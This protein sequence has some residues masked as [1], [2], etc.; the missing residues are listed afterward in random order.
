ML[1][2]LLLLFCGSNSSMFSSARVPKEGTCCARTSAK[3]W[4]RG[5]LLEEQEGVGSVLLPTGH[6]ASRRSAVRN[7]RSHMERA[8]GNAL[9]SGLGPV[10]LSFIRCRGAVE[11][12]R[13]GLW[14]VS[15]P[16]CV[17]SISRDWRG[18][19]AHASHLAQG[20]QVRF[21]VVP[22]SSV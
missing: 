7:M 9:W 14:F 4:P 12:T 15:L 20:Y 16:A 21:N 5:P 1:L 8:K 17:T 18:F 22:W 3:E 6:G 10:V 19:L 11:E 13:A 2:S